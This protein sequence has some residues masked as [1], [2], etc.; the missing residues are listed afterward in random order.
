[1][2]IAVSV[3]VLGASAALPLV[4]RADTPPSRWDIAKDPGVRHRYALHVRVREL[5]LLDRQ[6]GRSMRTAALERAR[7][8]LEDEH[9][10]TSPDVRLRFDLGEVYFELG[11]HDRAIAVL[12][13]ALEESPDHPAAIEA[14]ISLAYAFAK[15]GRSKE[16]RANYQAYLAK[17]TDDRLRAL[18]ILNMAE[19]EMHLGDLEESIASYKESLAIATHLPNSSSSSETAVLALWGLAVALDRSGDA[20]AALEQARLA[21]QMDPGELIIGHGANVFFVPE[22]ERQWY[23]ALAEMAHARDARAANRPEDVVAASSRALDHWTKYVAAASDE[24][25]FIALARAHQMRATAALAIARAKLPQPAK[26][27]PKPPVSAPRSATQ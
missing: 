6:I 8:I 3:A 23:L 15:L 1:M 22:Y 5:L 7:A 2:S 19:A 16:E 20:S 26:V 24:D 14:R 11:R 9:A 4:A 12:A 10:A 21:G 17:I 13:A 27:A 25:R 18:A